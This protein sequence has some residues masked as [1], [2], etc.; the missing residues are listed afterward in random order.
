MSGLLCALLILQAAP[1]AEMPPPPVAGAL[2]IQAS[3]QQHAAAD[4]AALDRAGQDRAALGR[5]DPAASH[6]S[7]AVH[8]RWL[9]TMT[10]RFDGPEGMLETLPDGRLQVQVGLRAASVTFPDSERTTRW[11]RSD[12]FFDVA[13]YPVIR[14]RSEP[15]SRARL[16]AGGALDGLLE[17]RGVNKPV[18]FELAKSDC[19]QPGAGCPIHAVGRISR[20]A[21]GMT[22]ML[23]LVRDDVEFAFDVRL[24]AQP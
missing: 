24:R 18:R 21:F 2:S 8:T 11:T 7:F 19:A 6:A 20:R 10:G 1:A 17:V 13:H 9:S 16:G 14:F 15:F 23:W 4:R 12:A 3:D 22:R 5:F